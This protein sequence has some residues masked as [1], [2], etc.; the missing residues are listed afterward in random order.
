LL[1]TKI[2]C[3][4][5]IKIKLLNAKTDVLLITNYLNSL[6]AVNKASKL[7]VSSVRMVSILLKV[8]GCSRFW[9]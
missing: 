2:R 6:N 3:V 9:S 1:Q 5:L 4:L 8:R 7:I